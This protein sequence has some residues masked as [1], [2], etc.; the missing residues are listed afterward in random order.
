MRPRADSRGGAEKQPKDG[1]EDEGQDRVRPVSNKLDTI[2][3]VSSGAIA[4]FVLFFSM[5]R[6]LGQLDTFPTD[7]R[8]RR[9]IEF[10]MTA[11][12]WRISG[13]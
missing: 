8:A 12:P 10:S 7:L 9:G 2:D 4:G 13:E 6:L 5:L 1:A 3:R 11:L